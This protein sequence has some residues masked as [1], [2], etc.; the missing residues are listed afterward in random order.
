M[1]IKYKRSSPE[2]VEIFEDGSQEKYVVCWVNKTSGGYWTIQK[3]N[4]VSFGSNDHQ[5]AT[6]EEAVNAAKSLI[7]DGKGTE[8]TAALQKAGL[9][10]QS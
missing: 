2:R 5:Y 1:A 3:E 6:A 10:K 9:T 7:V 8:L 4:G